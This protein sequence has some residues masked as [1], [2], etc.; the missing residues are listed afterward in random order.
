MA[1][2][3]SPTAITGGTVL[4]TGPYMTGDVAVFSCTSGYAMTG[5]S[6][7]TCT[8]GV[9]STSPTC[10][11][12]N[13]NTVYVNLS[14]YDNTSFPNWL[15]YVLAITCG[16]L[17]LLLVTCLLVWCCQLLGCYG[18]STL[19]G[20]HNPTNSCLCCCRPS[21]S[22]Y[23]GYELRRVCKIHPRRYEY[24]ENGRRFHYDDYGRSCYKMHKNMNGNAVSNVTI[25]ETLSEET[26]PRPTFVTAVNEVFTEK[27]LQSAKEIHTWRPHANPVR[28]INTSTK[29]YW[30]M[31][32]QKYK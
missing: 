18:K 4:T 1:N 20:E 32:S 11:L 31:N 22:A 8:N 5:N 25:S 28:N 23:N 30:K 9:W 26:T 17:A 16:I 10:S 15:A 29:W 2:C 12:Q 6:F 7:I 21:N 27:K 19:F 24:D 13:T 3:T 14:E